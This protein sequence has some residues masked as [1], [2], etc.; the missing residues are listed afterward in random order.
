MRATSWNGI[1]QIADCYPVHLQ[2]QTQHRANRQSKNHVVVNKSFGSALLLVVGCFATSVFSFLKGHEPKA[3]CTTFLMMNPKR[4][5]IHEGIVHHDNGASGATLGSFLSLVHRARNDPREILLQSRWST[6][7][8]KLQNWALRCAEGDPRLMPDVWVLN[9]RLSHYNWNESRNVNLIVFAKLYVG[10]GKSNSCKILS[11]N[12]NF[13][14]YSSR[15][16]FSIPLQPG[17][18]VIALGRFASFSVKQSQD[19]QSGLLL[20]HNGENKDRCFSS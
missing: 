4:S 18:I 17:D 10:R 11:L 13:I 3:P 14:R 9:I 19:R 20:C 1:D 6:S 5:T 16:V 2:M 8:V 7:K 15:G 12:L